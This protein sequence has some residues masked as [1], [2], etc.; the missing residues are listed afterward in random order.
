[1]VF[2]SSSCGTTTRAITKNNATGTATTITITTTNTSSPQVDVSPD[3]QLKN[4]KDE[5]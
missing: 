2:F 3:V 1:M 5:K 4:T